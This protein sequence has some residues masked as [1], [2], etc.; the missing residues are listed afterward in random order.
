MQI[1]WHLT[2]C[3]NVPGRIA[4][5]DNATGI[6]NK[7]SVHVHVLR[8]IT[9]VGLS[10]LRFETIFSSRYYEQRY[11]RQYTYIHIYIPS[12]KSESKITRWIT[13]PRAWSSSSRIERDDCHLSSCRLVSPFFF[14]PPLLGSSSLSRLLLL[15]FFSQERS[16]DYTILSG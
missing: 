12:R 5:I 16:R 1:S 11:T 15:L 4:F 9:F 14:F 10:S 3:R 13:M 6:E 7:A 8:G 2:R